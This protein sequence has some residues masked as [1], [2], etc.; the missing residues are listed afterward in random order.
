MATKVKQSEQPSQSD[1]A[2][3]AIIA[4]AMAMGASV[5]ATANTLSPVVGIPAPSLTLALL[6]ATSKPTTY[7]IA[8]LPSASAL[9]E[10]QGL[11]ATY[12][13]QYVLA[14]SR[15]VQSALE[16]GT[17]REQV[18]TKER[19]YFQQHL[20]A[21][22]NRRK[23]AKQVDAMAQRYGD[24]LG[25][26]AKMDSRTSAEC[27][28]ANGKNFNASTRPPIGYPGSVHPNCRCKAG[29]PFNTRATVYSIVPEKRVA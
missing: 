15:R 12:R 4:G 8:T 22:A 9:S 6:I 10:A 18:L 11:E 3:I 14:A 25:W 17:P 19:V 24:L 2:L 5:Q 7:G 20:D 27:R 26:Y 21:I 23:S 16:A 13:A 28:A 29:K 1:A